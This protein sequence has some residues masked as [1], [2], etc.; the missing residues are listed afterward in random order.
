MH[1]AQITQPK[2]SAA[3]PVPKWQARSMERDA[4]THSPQRG[5]EP[6]TSEVVGALCQRRTSATELLSIRSSDDRTQRD[7]ALT[8]TGGT[9]EPAWGASWAWGLSLITVTTAVHALGV[10][11]IF[12]GLRR[13]DQTGSVRERRIRHPIA[14]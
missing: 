14:H 5:P 4:I 3:L 10:V 6:S 11:M 1:Q 7:L 9:I 2:W 13:R 8:V 12:R